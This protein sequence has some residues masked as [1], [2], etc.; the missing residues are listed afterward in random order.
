MG[1]SLEFYAGDPDQIGAAFTEFALDGLRAGRLAHSCAD[2]SLHLSPNDLD[3]LSEQIGAA[4]GRS[5]LRLLE[6]LERTV[7]GT[8]DESGASVVSPNWVAAVAA[9]PADQIQQPT[10]SW[11]QAV[12]EAS[13]EVVG[14]DNPEA[15]AAVSA[16][17]SL[18]RE[19]LARSTR[20]VFAWYL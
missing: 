14:G 19:A 9:V 3:L 7:G 1:L 8:P 18:C 4:L 17:V 15:V 10:R 16:L 20:V 6:S 13:G 5:P 2:L 12:A 11:L